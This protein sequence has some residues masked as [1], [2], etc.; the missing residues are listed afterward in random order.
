MCFGSVEGGE[1]CC[2]GFFICGLC[3]GEAG[4]VDAVVDVVVGPVVCLFDLFLQVWWEEFYVL[5]FLGEEVVELS[6]HQFPSIH[7]RSLKSDKR[8]GRG[9]NEPQNKTSV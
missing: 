9:Q 2:D 6:F 5:V 7:I 4:F 8:A 1:E 3:G